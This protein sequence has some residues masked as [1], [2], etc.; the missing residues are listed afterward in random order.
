MPFN[1]FIETACNY[2]PSVAIVIN[3]TQQKRFMT[4]YRVSDDHHFEN[5]NLLLFI[6]KSLF[7]FQHYSY[8]MF[9]C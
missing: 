7:G 6:V 5:T 9:L 8:R 2:L 1:I 4:S 3:K